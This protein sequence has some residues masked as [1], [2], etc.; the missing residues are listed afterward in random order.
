MRHQFS[1][2]SSYFRIFNSPLSPKN[3]D[4]GINSQISISAKNCFLSSL[5]HVRKLVYLT[6]FIQKLKWGCGNF[7]TRSTIFSWSVSR[8]RRDTMWPWR[9]AVTRVSMAWAWA[10]ACWGRR[11]GS[12]PPP[13][14]ARPPR[15]RREA[16]EMTSLHMLTSLSTTLVMYLLNFAM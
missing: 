9:Q 13:W 15:T 1:D 3:Y 6:G 10:R 5:Q 8:W 2:S 7:W 12:A 16:R 11:V 14:A 4:L